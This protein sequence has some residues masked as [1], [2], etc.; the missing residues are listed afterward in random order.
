MMETALTPL[1]VQA[2]ATAAV[3]LALRVLLMV[4]VGFARA[5]S[6]QFIGDGDNIPFLL[7]VRRRDDT[8]RSG[9]QRLSAGVG[10]RPTGLNF[11]NSAGR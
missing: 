2:A 8:Q 10:R 5:R 3:I 1:P 7:V 6:G 9:N 4:S 11:A